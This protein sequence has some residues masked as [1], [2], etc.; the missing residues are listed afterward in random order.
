MNN[1]A[2]KYFTI[3]LILLAIFIEFTALVKIVDVETLGIEGD[4]IGFA[5][6]NKSIFSFLGKSSFWLTVTDILGVIV[7]MV[8]ATFALFGFCQLVKRKSIK[9]IDPPILATGLLYVAVIIFYIIFEFYVINYAPIKVDGELKPSYPSSHTL[10]AVTVMT[11]AAS[12][13]NL[14]AKKRAHRIAAYSIATAIAALTVI[15][16]LLAGV[17]WFTDIF[18]SLILSAAL[19]FFLYGVLE[20]CCPIEIIDD[21]EETE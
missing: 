18:A 17:H 10:L 20:L 11:S 5:T 13:F 12:V 7:L 14:Y 2:K 6:I 21:T 19:I 3:G 8:A 16:R 15:G 1:I 4:T 9:K